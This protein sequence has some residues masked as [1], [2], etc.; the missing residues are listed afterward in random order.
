MALTKAQLEALNNQSFP[1]NNSGF[2]TPEILRTYNSSSIAAF[3]DEND[4]IV[5]SASFSDRINAITASGGVPLGTVSSSAQIVGLGFATTASVN[6]LSASIFTTDSTQTNLING[7][8]NTSSFTPFSTSVDSRLDGLEF[9][10]GTFV[11]TASFNTFSTSVDSRLDSEEFKST[12]FATT[13]S[14]TFVGNQTI[15]GNVNITGSLTAS[16]LKYPTVDGTT[17][18]VIITDGAGNLSFTT[19]AVTAISEDVRYGETIAVGDPLYVNGSSGNRPIVFKADAGDPL[20]MPVIYVASTAGGVNTNTKALTLG[21][22]TGVTTT[23]Y[24]A[25][26]EVFVGVGGGWTA[27]R[28]TGTAIVQSLGIVTKEGSGGSGRGLILNPGPAN[29]PNISEGYVWV[30]DSNSYP[31]AVAT[32]SFGGSTDITAL[33]NFTASQEFLNT[34]FVT[35]SSFNAFTQSISSSVDSLSSSVGLLQ[36][37]SGSE[38]KNDS[39]SFDSRINAAGGQLQ[40]QDEGTIQGNA[41]SLN[42]TGAGV[43]VSITSNTASVTIAGGGGSG[44]VT[45]GANVFTGSQTISSSLSVVNYENGGKQNIKILPFISGAT[46]NGVRDTV[47][48]ERF[49]TS[50]DGVTYIPSPTSPTNLIFGR[51]AGGAAAATV[52]ATSI[53]SGSNNIVIGERLAAANAAEIESNNSV[54]TTFPSTR[55]PN[56]G[57]ARFQNST[58]NGAVTVTNNTAGLSSSLALGSVGFGYGY[59]TSMVG[60][61]IYGNTTLNP[62][63]S[64]ISVN[65]TVNS[66]LLTINGNKINPLFTGNGSGFTLG[67][68]INTGTTTLIDLASGSWNVGQTLFNRNLF[69]G[70]VTATNQR[71]ATTNANLQNAIVFGNNLIVTG[72]DAAGSPN[73]GGSA[74]FGKYNLNDGVINNTANVVFAVGAGTGTGTNTR[75]PLWIGTDQSVNITGSLKVTGS[76]FSIDTDAN[77]TASSILLKGLGSTAIQYNQPSFGGVDGVYATSYG[78]DNLKVYQYQGQGYAFNVNLTADQLNAYTG[79]QFRWGLQVNGSDVSLPG[80]GGTYFSMVSG[81]NTG[82]NDNPGADKKG[83][84]YLGTSMI[85]DMNAD[86]SFRRKVYVEGGMFVSG[87]TGGSNPALKVDGTSAGGTAI[88]ATGSVNITGSLT[89][90]GATPLLSAYGSYTGSSISSGVLTSMTQEF[91]SGV[92]N[93]SGSFLRVTTTGVYQVTAIANFDAEGG[94][95]NNGIDI[96]KNGTLIPTTTVNGFFTGNAQLGGISTTTLVQLNAFEYVEIGINPA[97][98]SFLGARISINRVG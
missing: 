4:Y 13:A 51:N 21:L 19:N 57:P 31:T 87:S 30:G 54:I 42:F 22:I 73:V 77:V 5:D 80:G 69:G 1:D 48:T 35:T 46:F 71:E 63:S 74:F 26:T 81:S 11:N 56:Y 97:D 92:E 25:G 62:N 44:E 40:I 50:T 95:A 91:A 68:S 78:K 61:A 2:I 55:T 37:F 65:Q 38:Y 98:D 94:S 45:L 34:T 82:S 32:S 85:L 7:K 28:P 12:T 93:V 72:S 18:Q 39:S 29:L 33:N 9:K 52:T 59:A 15:N 20:K 79:S 66:G 96:R 41:T 36:T 17:D 6:S 90:N 86:T 16:G 89:V 53:V 76:N 64:S 84:D 10:D 27:T 67:S 23:G 49:A 70:V 14:N 58:L 83:L 75:T 88:S 24:P 3:V 60:S 43:S 8:L 47:I